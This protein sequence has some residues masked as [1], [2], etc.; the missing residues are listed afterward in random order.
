MRKDG[1]MIAE[2]SDARSATVASAA[3]GEVCYNFCQS[4]IAMS[5]SYR[6]GRKSVVVNKSSQGR[7]RD[8]V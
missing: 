3:P 5:D 7:C 1:V 4:A 6:Y 2:G 8:R